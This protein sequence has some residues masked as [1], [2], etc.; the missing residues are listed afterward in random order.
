MAWWLRLLESGSTRQAIISIELYMLTESYKLYYSNVMKKPQPPH[1]WRASAHAVTRYRQRVN[2]NATY[3]D[4]AERLI[5]RARTATWRMALPASARA[6]AEGRATTV[7][8]RSGGLILVADLG[9]RL[10]VTCY[11]EGER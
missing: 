7:E 1:P 11:R 2:S 6:W 4:A 3:K 10:V 9:E 8:F 5:R